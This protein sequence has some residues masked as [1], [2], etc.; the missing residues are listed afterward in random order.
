MSNYGWNMLLMIRLRAG[1]LDQR[2]YAL[3]NKWKM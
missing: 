3:P 2:S 1:R